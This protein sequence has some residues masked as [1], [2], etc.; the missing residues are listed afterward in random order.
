LRFS[1]PRYINGW[2]NLATAILLITEIVAATLAGRNTNALASECT[3]SG[4]RM[5]ERAQFAGLEF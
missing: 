3:E 5:L 4:R 2:H 1:F